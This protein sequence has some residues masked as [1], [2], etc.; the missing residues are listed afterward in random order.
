MNDFIGNNFYEV[1]AE[2]EQPIILELEEIN[3]ID[4]KL[5]KELAKHDNDAKYLLDILEK[6]NG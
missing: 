2:A 4:I 6:N 3:K 5:L 1:I